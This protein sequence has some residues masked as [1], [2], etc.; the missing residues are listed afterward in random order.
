[1]IEVMERT[2]INN[3]E[4]LKSSQDKNQEI[5][6]AQLNEILVESNKKQS[7]KRAFDRVKE[8]NEQKAAS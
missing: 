7:F 2:A 8:R 6:S 4:G 5:A 3:S 1:M